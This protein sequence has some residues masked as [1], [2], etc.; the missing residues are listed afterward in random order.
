MENLE[1]QNELKCKLEQMAAGMGYE[2]KA[3]FEKELDP[4]YKTFQ[5]M[6]IF[7]FLTVVMVMGTYLAIYLSDKPDCNIKPSIVYVEKIIEKKI[8]IKEDRTKNLKL[9]KTK[10]IKGRLYRYYKSNNI[11][12][13]ALFEYYT[14]SELIK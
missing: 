9:F 6:I 14:T 13:E 12:K 1:N 3:K 2:I 8:F 11:S 10:I 5:T 4:I 7:G